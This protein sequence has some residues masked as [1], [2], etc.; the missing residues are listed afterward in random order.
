M[1]GA[2]GTKS[3]EDILDG[4]RDEE[5]RILALNPTPRQPSAHLHTLPH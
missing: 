3:M 5:D 2:L 4:L 1:Y